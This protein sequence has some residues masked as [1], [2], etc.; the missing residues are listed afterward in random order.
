MTR[1]FSD[2]VDV[3]GLT[4]EERSKLERVHDLL[5]AAGPPA[6]LPSE[7]ERPPAQVIQFPV[8]RRRP[9]AV[10]LVAAAA[11]VAASFAGGFVVGNDNHH[12]MNAIEVVDFHGGSNALASLRIGQ[13]DAVGNNP[14]LLTVSGL[15]TLQHGY[16][17]L[18]MVKNGKPVFPCT[19]FRVTT[20]G[21]MSVR[22]SVPYSVH[23]GVQLEITAVQRGKTK[24]PGRTVMQSGTV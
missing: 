23:P 8:W 10:A 4:P 24:W 5:V 14:M 16:Y 2:W 9:L 3:E 20:G 19:G 15:P 1:D 11:L 18:F 22:F 6:D 7:L 17:E 12:T 13:P 21:A